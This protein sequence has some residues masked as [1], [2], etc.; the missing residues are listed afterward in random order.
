MPQ[1]QRPRWLSTRGVVDACRILPGHPVHEALTGYHSLRSRPSG[2]ARLR[3]WSPGPDF[4]LDLSDCCDIAADLHGAL[5]PAG[6]RAVPARP[7]RCSL[8][9]VK[10]AKYS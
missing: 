10:A 8:G 6:M 9:F 1:P 4:M 3:S 5:L 7:P 2:D